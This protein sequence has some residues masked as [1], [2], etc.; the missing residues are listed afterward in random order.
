[1]A[2]LVTKRSEIGPLTDQFEAVGLLDPDG[3]LF[4]FQFTP[5]GALIVDATFSGTIT[6]GAVTLKDWDSATQLDIELDV[7]HNALFVQSDS[8]ASEVTLKAVLDAIVVGTGEVW[9]S[10]NDNTAVIK[11]VETTLLT[12]IVPV[13][14]TARVKNFDGSGTADGL[15]RLKINGAT[16]FTGRLSWNNR[17]LIAVLDTLDVTAG[18]SITVTVYHTEAQNQTFEVA[19]GGLLY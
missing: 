8:L 19:I 3:V 16:K 4:G 5:A 10:Y 12:Y 6:I 9:Y 14:K 17:N 1:M 15:F 18:N 2:N 7:T 13:G 11:N